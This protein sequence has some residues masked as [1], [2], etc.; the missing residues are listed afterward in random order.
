MPFEFLQQYEFSTYFFHYF[1]TN[2]MKSLSQ[3]KFTVHITILSLL[4][5]ETPFCFFLIV[6]TEIYGSKK[7]HWNEMINK[8]NVLK[9]H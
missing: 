2:L 5:E 3:A 1:L 4:L 7:N 8:L 9:M 6:E